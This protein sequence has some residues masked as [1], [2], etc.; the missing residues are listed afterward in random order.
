MTR[1]AFNIICGVVI[2][3]FVIWLGHAF[4]W[5]LTED[6]VQRQGKINRESYGFQQAHR[7]ELTHEI[8]QVY[9]ITSQMTG[10][11][12][13]QAQ[14]LGAQRWAIV[15]QACQT[16]SQIT[17]PLPTDQATWVDQNCSAGTGKPGSQYA[18]TTS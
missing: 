8:A 13:D 10:A 7:D 5:W 16:A 3:G 1:T 9:T 18:P 4:G 12:G 17:D 2:V 6:S 11:S 14:A 15:G